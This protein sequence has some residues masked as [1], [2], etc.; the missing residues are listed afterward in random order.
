MVIYKTPVNR[1]VVGFIG[2]LFMNFIKGEQR[3]VGSFD[4]W[5]GLIVSL[6]QFSGC[7]S[8]IGVWSQALWV[9]EN[10]QIVGVVELVECFGVESYVHFRW[11]G[12]VIVV[13]VFSDMDI[14]MGE[15]LSVD[16]EFFKIYCFDVDGVVL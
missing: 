16:I 2:L 12:H 8:E 14:R 10:G 5:G 15:A 13:Q 1:F 3:V 7:V 6:L 11:G 9:S 4:C